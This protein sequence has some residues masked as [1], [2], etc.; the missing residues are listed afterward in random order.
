MDRE[1]I[2]RF[3]TERF[4]AAVALG[5]EVTAIAPD[6]ASI[7]LATRDDH[8]RPGGTVSGP[9]LMTLADTAMYVALLARHGLDAATGLTSSLEV[10][11]LAR[12][13]PGR[14]TADC[15]ILKSGRR[16]SVGVVDLRGD[17]GT[18]CA[19]ATVTYALPG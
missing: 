17:D 6:G 15:R 10:H 12:A 16:L 18:L 5:F 19:H 4:P 7:A 9:T 8:L 1:G 2:D 13:M 11:F 3:F 14:V